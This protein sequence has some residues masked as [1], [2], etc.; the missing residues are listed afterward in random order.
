MK[1]LDEEVGETGRGEGG[2]DCGGNMSQV[3]MVIM[4]VATLAAAAYAQYRIPFHTT[5]KSHLWFSRLL[6][7]ILGVIFGWV[8]SNRYPVEGFTKALVF[9]SAFGIVH[10]P[11]AFIL[12]IKRQRH[13]WR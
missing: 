2:E 5:T 10:V 6:L 7:L 12:F 4:T 3:G 8:T 11:A 13:E 1:R 9:L